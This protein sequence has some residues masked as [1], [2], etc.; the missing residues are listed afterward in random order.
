MF[1]LLLSS[2]MEMKL[3]FQE[4]N[5][6]GVSTILAL[7]YLTCLGLVTVGLFFFVV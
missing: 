6:L 7:F 3:V 1:D 5:A 4:G 2:L